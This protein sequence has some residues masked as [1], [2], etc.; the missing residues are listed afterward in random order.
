MF[1]N[2]R[3]KGVNILDNEYTKKVLDAVSRAKSK[4]QS[5]ERA[6]NSEKRSLEYE[7][8]YT[9]FN[10]NNMSKAIDF[11]ARVKRATDELYTDYESIVRFLDMECRSFLAY[12]VSASAIKKVADL[13][14]EIN[15]D[16]S[17]LRSNIS[18]T[19]FSDNLGDLRTEQYIASIEAKSI[20]KF[21]FNAYEKTPEA[22]EEQKR[23]AAEME[24]WRKLRE[25]QA[26][27]AEERRKKEAEER[28]RIEKEKAAE[29]KRIAEA[30][31]TAKAYMDK[32]IRECDNKVAEFRKK[33]QNEIQN[34]RQIYQ[35][36]IDEEIS[37]AQASIAEQQKKLSE[38]G[39]F[40]LSEKN[41]AK[42]KIKILEMRILKYQNPLIISE[43][44]DKMHEISENAISEYRK[45]IDKYL[46]KRFS[47]INS[48]QSSKTKLMYVENANMASQPYPSHKDIKKIFE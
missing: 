12:D 35:K 38:L 23:K 37:K 42:K 24:K 48:T 14:K 7:A 45:E 11:V 27:E 26:K 39:F 44:I 46:S 4:V 10:I 17:D 30:N 47:D 6:F 43:E 20:E 31:A 3:L 1:K 41:E 29:E 33:L 28:K 16:S 34:Q 19:F 32:C 15:R 8:N 25:K 5:A 36:E 13:I 2:K 40:K 9:T 21:W 18:G 22:K